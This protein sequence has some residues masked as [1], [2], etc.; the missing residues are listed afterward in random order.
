[1]MQPAD[2]V[3]LLSLLHPLSAHGKS[4]SS[5]GDGGPGR[6]SE[7]ECHTQKQGAGSVI[8][9]SRRPGRAATIK[10]VEALGGTTPSSQHTNGCQGM[11]GGGQGGGDKSSAYINTTHST[12]DM[13]SHS[14]ALAS[15]EPS[16]AAH[17]TT[18]SQNAHGSSA[19]QPHPSVPKLSLSKVP[20]F[21]SGEARYHAHTDTDQ[22][23]ER[24]AHTELDK[25]PRDRLYH[26]GGVSSVCACIHVYVCVCVYV[27]VYACVCVCVCV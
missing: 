2:T 1:M 14:R 20:L 8:N 7:V 15:Q 26:M 6:D 5:T 24:E 25:S 19:A 23:G 21:A 11:L 4:A 12:T 17:Y 16:C 13:N 9:V 10:A 27:C 3:S 18:Q 22:G